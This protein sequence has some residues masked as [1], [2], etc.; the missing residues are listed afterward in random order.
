MRILGMRGREEE[1][2]YGIWEEIRV[3]GRRW[4]RIEGWGRRQRELGSQNWCERWPL[5]FVWL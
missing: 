5:V 3:K 2:V 1:G 4:E